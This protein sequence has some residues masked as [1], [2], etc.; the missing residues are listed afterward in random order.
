MERYLY[1]EY[2]M[3]QIEKTEFPRLIDIRKR[4][5]QE[6]YEAEF[7]GDDKKSLALKKEI[8]YIE[9]SISIGEEY[10]VPF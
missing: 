4:L 6:Y 7:I 3:M 2:E 8:E 10:D 5:L 9:Y 1:D